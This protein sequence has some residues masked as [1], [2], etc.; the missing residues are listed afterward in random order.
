MAENNFRRVLSLWD[1][2]L[3]EIAEESSG[4][5]VLVAQGLGTDREAFRSL[6]RATWLHRVEDEDRGEHKDDLEW[7]F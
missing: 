6:S 5:P 7:N 3:T 1:I 4:V 2:Y